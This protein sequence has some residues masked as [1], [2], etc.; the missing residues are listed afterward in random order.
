VAEYHAVPVDVHTIPGTAESSVL[1]RL[2]GVARTGVILGHSGD[3]ADCDHL[4]EL[5]D[6][7]SCWAMDRSN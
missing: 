1:S 4:A 7:G 3:T 2:R 6:A 5:A